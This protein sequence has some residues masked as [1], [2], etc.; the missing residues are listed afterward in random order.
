MHFS[1]LAS[2]KKVTFGNVFIE[3]NAVF[4]KEKGRKNVDN[5]H[6]SDHIEYR[7]KSKEYRVKIKE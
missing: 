1:K 2:R 4:L 5:V 3:N 7:E 6:P